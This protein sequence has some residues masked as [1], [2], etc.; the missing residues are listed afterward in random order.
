V[1][2]DTNEIAVVTAHNPHDIFRP[3]VKVVADRERKKIEGPAVDLSTREES[4]SYAASIV[5]ALS[6]EEYGVNIAEVLV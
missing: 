3:K 1:L 2:L 5:S 4:G 6:P